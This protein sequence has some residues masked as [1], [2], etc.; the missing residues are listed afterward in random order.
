MKSESFPL[1]P[2]SHFC[3]STSMEIRWKYLNDLVNT[4]R[5]YIGNTPNM[6]YA[7]KAKIYLERFRKHCTNFCPN[8]VTTKYGAL[9][10]G[11]T[12]TLTIP[13][14]VNVVLNRFSFGLIVSLQKQ[15]CFKKESRKEKVN[16]LFLHSL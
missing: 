4:H 15:R 3:Q 1:S 7:I 11:F 16:I 13:E 14:I 6:E 2:K 12:I 5:E 10:F 9:F 8:F